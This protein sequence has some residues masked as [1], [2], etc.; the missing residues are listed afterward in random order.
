VRDSLHG[1]A[2]GLAV[3]DVSLHDF[4][5]RMRFGDTIV[6]KSTNDNVFMQVGLQH[7]TNEMGA[8]FAGGAGYQDVFHGF[9]HSDGM[10]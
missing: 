3:G 1:L 10:F 4:K 5:A 7:M 2:H 6:T 9:R 8:D